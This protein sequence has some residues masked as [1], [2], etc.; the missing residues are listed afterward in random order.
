MSSITPNQTP[1]QKARDIIDQM[2]IKAGWKI[3]DNKSIDFGSKIRVL[4]I[5][6]TCL[7]QMSLQKTLLKIL[8]RDLT[9]FEKYWWDWRVQRD[10]GKINNIDLR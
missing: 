3:Q 5:S 4:P 7:N 9:V 6:I 8:K 10:W 1:E 2:L